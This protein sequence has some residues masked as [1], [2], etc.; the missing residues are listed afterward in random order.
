[1]PSAAF[2][3]GM[4]CPVPSVGPAL[5]PQRAASALAAA[6]RKW[7]GVEAGALHPAVPWF[8]TSI[9]VSV[10]NFQ[11]GNFKGGMKFIFR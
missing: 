6:H 4:G 7:Y 9:W 2:C 5:L 8:L 3:P 10:E 1:M 11:P